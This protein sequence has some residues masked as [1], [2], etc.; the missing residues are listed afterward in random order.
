[1]NDANSIPAAKLLM[2]LGA[3]GRLLQRE[4]PVAS[5]RRA[6]VTQGFTNNEISLVLDTL[7]YE[8]TRGLHVNIRIEDGV[9]YWSLVGVT[10]KA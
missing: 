2:G 5:L 3:L 6:L 4:Q 9:Y 8:R 1:M 7:R 10:F